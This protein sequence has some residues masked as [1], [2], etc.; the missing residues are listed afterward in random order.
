MKYEPPLIDPRPLDP[1]TAPP[2]PDTAP[3]WHL[4]SSD[5]ELEDYAD[6]EDELSALLP[7]YVAHG[8]FTLY[9]ECTH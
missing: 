6:T 1:P 4:L 3:Y 7:T 8:S 5:H 2:E 9:R